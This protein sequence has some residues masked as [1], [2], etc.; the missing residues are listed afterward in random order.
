MRQSLTALEIAKFLLEYFKLWD[1]KSINY[2]RGCPRIKAFVYTLVMAQKIMI[3]GSEEFKAKLKAGRTYS[4]RRMDF[5]F[6]V[7][8]ASDTTTMAYYGSSV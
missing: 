7:A 1:D 8:V 5:V 2:Q 3:D 6:F 4:M